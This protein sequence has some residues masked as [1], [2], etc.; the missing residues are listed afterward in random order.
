MGVALA[1]VAKNWSARFY[2]AGIV[3]YLLYVVTIGGDYMV[4]RFLTAPF[5][6]AVVYLVSQP[7]IAWSRATFFPLLIVVLLIG[8]MSSQQL[9]LI[10]NSHFAL[11]EE[12]A[13]G[14]SDERSWYNIPLGLLNSTR[15]NR[16]YEMNLIQGYVDPHNYAAGGIG[17]NGFN[18][19]SYSHI[20]DLIGLADPLIARLPACYNPQW[21]MGHP[22]RILPPGY[23][24][25]QQLGR[26][27]IE[28]SKTS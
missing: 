6:A 21:R 26:N 11:R 3:L 16:A 17:R 12:N 27:L 10:S 2:A 19:S 13:E 15:H 8:V 23:L 22:E 18:A 9:P 4:G 14:V 5:V 7:R 20:V 25:T 28:D 1:L 24:E